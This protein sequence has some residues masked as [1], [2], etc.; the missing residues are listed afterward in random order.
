MLG[1]YV[2]YN[3][4]SY[5][6]IEVTPTQFKLNS[7]EHGRVK[8][9]IDKCTFL[10]CDPAKMISYKEKSYLV[11]ITGLIISLVSGNFMKWDHNNG[12][13]TAC[14]YLAGLRRYATP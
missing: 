1:A 3:S 13:R 8:V 5:I 11:T 9:N 12:N 7:P 2:K 4:K 10:K 14:L 6:I